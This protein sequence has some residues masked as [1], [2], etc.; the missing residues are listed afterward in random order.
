MDALTPAL[1]RAR[2]AELREDAAFRA[3]EREAGTMPAGAS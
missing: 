3:R 1:R 2:L